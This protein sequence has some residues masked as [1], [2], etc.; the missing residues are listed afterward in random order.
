MTGGGVGH[1]QGRI[2]AL[3]EE[4]WLSRHLYPALKGTLHRETQVPLRRWLRYFLEAGQVSV[5]LSVYISIDLSIC[6][7]TF[8]EAKLLQFDHLAAQKAEGS[9]H[10]LNY[11]ATFDNVAVCAVLKKKDQKERGSNSRPFDS[12]SSLFT[13]RLHLQTVRSWSAP[14][15]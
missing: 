11:I 5:C 12:P 4:L 8:V 15:T 7:Y 6:R 2:P 13:T 14:L 1:L 9:P 10:M 3:D